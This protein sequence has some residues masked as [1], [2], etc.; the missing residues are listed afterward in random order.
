MHGR[1]GEERKTGRHMWKGLTHSNSVV[2]CDVS[3]SSSSVFPANSFCKDG[4]RINVGDCALFKPPQDSPPFIGIIRWATTGEEDELKLGVN[5]LY[6]PSELKLGKGI[7]L[8]AE[9][10][11]IFYSF[12]KDEIP[13]A[14]L[15]HPCRVAFLPKGAELPS[16]ICSFVCRRVYDITNKCLWWL[17]DQDYINE[18]QEEVDQLLCKT[19]IEMHATVSQGGHSPKPTNG[20]TSTS[21]LK[22]SSDSVQN[23]VSSTPSQ[24]KGKKRERIDQGSEPVKR[25]RCSKLDYG[26]SGHCRP[27]SIWKTEIAKFTEKGGLVDSEGVEKLVQLMVPERNEKK[28]D[29][30]GRSILAGVIAATDKFDCLNRFVQVKGLPVFDEWLQ[31]VHKGKIGDGSSHKDSDKSV[32]EFLFILLGALDKLPVNLH[33]LQM[34]NIGKSV[35]HLRTHKNLEIQ[36]KARSLVD[37]WKKRVEAEMD[38][39]SGS[40][41]A[42]SWAGR[43]R[44]PD[45]SHGG[46]RHSGTSS[47]V[48]IKSSATQLSASKNAPGKLLQVETATKS[49]SGSP[50]SMKSVPS[51]ASAGNCLNEGQTHNIGVSSASDHPIVALR[52]EK[53]SSSSQSHNNS[54]SCSSDHAK[55][56]GV[57]GKEDARSSTAVSMTANKVIGASSRHRKSINGIQ[58]STLSG[59]QRET[60]SSRNSSLHRSQAAEKLSQS[61]LTF[62]KAVDVPLTEGNNHKLVVKIPNR[63]CSPALCASGGSLEDPSVMNSRASSPLLSEKHEQFDRN[64]KEKNDCCRAS[65]MPDVNN[66]SWQSNDF[67]EVLTGSD[68]GDGSPATVPEEENCRTVEDTRKL[69]DVPKPASSSSGNE[70]KY[71]KLHE[72]SFSSINALIESCEKYSEVNASMSAGDDA[73]MNLLASVAAGEISKSDMGS[74]D[75]SPQRNITAVEHSCTSIDSR[76]KSSSGDDMRQTVDGGDDEHEK[77]GTDTSLTKSTEDKIV[78]LSEEKPAEVRNG[79]SNSSNMDVQKVTEPCLQNNVKSEET[80]ATSVTLLSSSSVDKTTNSDKETW[81]EK[82]DDISYTKDKLHSCIQSES[83]VDVSRLEG[84]TES[85]EG[86]LAG[87]SMEIDGDNR[88]NMNKEVN[89]TV[90]AEQKPPAV[91]C[92]EFAEGTVGDVHHP[93]GFGKDNFSETAVWEV[94][95]E[96]A[97]ERDGRSQPAE[98]G[99]N[100]QENNFVSNVSDRKVENLEGSVEDNKP[101]EQLSSAQALSNASPT[102]VQKP[103]QEAECRRLKLTGTDA[104]EAEE[105]T[106]GA[107]DAASLC[108]VRVANI[109]AKLEFDLNEGFNTDDGRY[110]EPNNSRTTEYSSGIQLVSPLPFPVSSSSSGLPASITVASAAKRPFIPPEDLLKN[111]G[112]L[113]WKGSAATSA[114]RPAEPRKTLEMP[115]GTIN[116]SF[117]DAAVVKP[118]RPPLDFDL[119]VPDERVLEDLASRGSARGSVAVFDLSNNHNPAHDQLMGSAAVRSS[120]GL[121]LD[122]NRVEDSSDMGNHFRSNTCRMDGRL[123]AVKSSSV[124]VLNGESSIRRDFD[125]NDGPLADEGSAE[126]SPFGQTTRNNASSQPSVSGLR[127]NN[128]EMGNFSSWLPQGNPYAAI[129]IQSMLPDRGEQSF[130]MVTPGGPQRMLGPPTGSTPFNPDVYRGPVLSSAPAVPFPAPPFQYPV[131][132]F[133]TNFPLPS[134]TLSV[135]ST[136]YL[137]SSSGGRLCFPAVHSQVLAPAGAV[138][139]HYPR[140]FV[141]SLQDSGNISGSESSRKWGRQGLDLNAGPLGPDLEGRDE[142]GSLA[143][144]QLSVASSQAIAE[145]HSRM[146][147]VASSGILKRKEPEGWEGYKQ[148]SWQ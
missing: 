70:H 80:L 37:T 134:A 53:S 12:H 81:E 125:L 30:V 84:R 45:V 20:P 2:A 148:S 27:E 4:R 11:E 116:I 5:W 34:C 140:P 120:G 121:D 119:N 144:R 8:E 128:T 33:A 127:L 90:K 102:F 22:P 113:G 40:N 54:Q 96:K 79:H 82:A 52:E 91:M 146:F 131:F 41:Q 105:S 92:S 110:G 9:P 50:G 57:S 38:A 43:P 7:L 56:G 101:K 71:G 61:S 111:R 147:Q 126:P 103:E 115:V 100:T 21:Q 99:N 124:A 142:T 75:N 136:T 88:K 74:P 35:N 130:A 51:S 89:L 108:A 139:S 97:G 25:E 36:K 39:K 49:A 76:L 137:D 29:L 85:V 48:A 23:S 143:S 17:T 13:A 118:S 14:S 132:P 63:G 66:E 59:T 62:E 133:G 94:K 112:E 15:L 72:A 98:R 32:E 107:A 114:F 58:G 67:K 93:T 10:N 86:S 77:R 65:I 123:Q 109:E 19:H 18:R 122:L 78:S 55:T 87:P 129:A 46:N 1:A 60:S 104:D 68:E 31:E 42:V 24:V 16:G 69:V 138:P 28:I 141:V 6:R 145:E 135:G 47:E 83:R 73:G 95:T 44:P 26:D 117:P 64:L 3:S 106:S